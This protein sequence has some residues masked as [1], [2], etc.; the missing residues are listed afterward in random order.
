[1]QGSVLKL[2]SQRLI[3][4]KED[5][6][7][8]FSFSIDLVTVAYK[9]SFKM[10]FKCQPT[11]VSES[12]MTEEQQEQQLQI[13]TNSSKVQ[14]PLIPCIAGRLSH[15]LPNLVTGSQVISWGK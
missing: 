4:C 14:T 8:I 12:R 15:E 1:M 3:P 6:F 11:K 5:V 13:R 7:K 2:E 10:Q 9:I